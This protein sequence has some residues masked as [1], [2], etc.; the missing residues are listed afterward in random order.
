MK[1][2]LLY[3]SHFI[4]IV[5]LLI[6]T[7]AAYFVLQSIRETFYQS[8][9][10]QQYEFRSLEED[11]E[12]YPVQVFHGVK[13]NTFLEEKDG[14]DRAIILEVKDEPEAKMKGFKVESDAEEMSAFTDAI[15]YKVMVDKK[16]GKESFIM[17]LRLTPES[18]QFRTYHVNENGVIKVSNFGVNRKS[19]METQWIRGLSGEKYGYYTNL[20][21]QK[22]STLSLIALTLIGISCVIGGR[23]L[24]RRA[25]EKERGDAA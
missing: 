10:D 24:R 25:L 17:A 5:G 9:F 14:P 7:L 3:V 8:R 23:G 11:G 2:R 16:T 22:G 15:Q 6:L 21:Y 4:F 12:V 19:K 18:K 1:K 20:P 13:V